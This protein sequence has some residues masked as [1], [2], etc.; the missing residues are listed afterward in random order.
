MAMR[1]QPPARP[2]GRALCESMPV[3][4]SPST[5]RPVWS[6]DKVGRGGAGGK[7]AMAGL[8][9]A[10]KRGEPPRPAVQTERPRPHPLPRLNVP[11]SPALAA[12]VPAGTSSTRTPSSPSCRRVWGGATV[13]PSTGRTTRPYVRIWS[14]KPRTVSM[15]M[16]NPTPELAPLPVGSAMAVL[17]PTR[18]PRESSSTPPELPGLMAASVWITFL[19]GTPLGPGVA[20][21]RPRPD[22]MPWVRVWSRPNGLPMANTFWPTC[23]PADAPTVTGRSAR[24]T[25]GGASSCSTATSLSGSPA[26]N[27]WWW[28]CR[29]R[30]GRQAV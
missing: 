17:M 28:W 23:R 22:T 3:I 4:M 8:W 15:G 11:L 27:F 1:V 12:G 7:P 29:G 13:T 24:M 18:R 30:S 26:M 10:G 16:A 6:L 25:S 20:S 9:A 14:T 19:M 2:R 21:S 5:R